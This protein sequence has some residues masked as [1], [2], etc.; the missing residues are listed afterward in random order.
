MEEKTD[1]TCLARDSGDI[2][3]RKSLCDANV[4]KAI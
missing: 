3:R 1:R 2:I 4:V